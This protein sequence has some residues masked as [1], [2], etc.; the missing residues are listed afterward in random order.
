MIERVPD[1]PTVKRPRRPRKATLQHDQQLAVLRDLDQH[2][3]ENAPI[4]WTLYF[5]GHRPAEVAALRVRDYKRKARQLDFAR[6]FSD[7][8]PRDGRKAGDEHLLPIPD[9]LCEIL[10][11]MLA[12]RN[13]GKVTPGPDALLFVPPRP[14][15]G[16]PPADHYR[17]HQLP[18][19]W[20]RACERAG[21]EYIGLYES[22]KHSLGRRMLELGLTRDQIGAVLGISPKM[23]EAYAEYEAEMLRPV[24]ERIHGAS[25]HSLP[26]EASGR[27]GKADG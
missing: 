20:R 1:V 3:P 14:R 26:T 9:Q 24:V 8:K 17:N 7:D 16:R 27:T 2:E 22:T 11:R 15:T 21:V 6:T 13:A 18:R 23:T 19:I 5:T 12:A 25:T 4:F 10:D